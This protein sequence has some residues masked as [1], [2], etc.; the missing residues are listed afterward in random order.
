MH[1]TK[2][3]HQRGTGS[4]SGWEMGRIAASLPSGTARNPFQTPTGPTA[5]E[6][7]NAYLMAGVSRS[8][9][10]TR[11]HPVRAV[12]DHRPVVGRS[13]AF[14]FLVARRSVGE[15][16]FP[17]SNPA[18]EMGPVPNVIHGTITWMWE[19]SLSR[20][21]IR[22]FSG[23]PIPGRPPKCECESRGYFRIALQGGPQLTARAPYS[24]RVRL[25][26]G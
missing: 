18:W 25:T 11:M 10:S 4:A 22:L 23:S 26:G 2:V 24:S 17:K 14:P 16:G 8:L 5:G 6:P 13:P 3:R 15:D 20:C 1:T 12:D 9:E 7:A 21:L 19:T